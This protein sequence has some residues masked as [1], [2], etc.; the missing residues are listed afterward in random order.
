MSE[1][2]ERDARALWQAL[3]P[4]RGAAPPPGFRGRVMARVRAE[5]G[6]ITGQVPSLTVLRWA[7]GRTKAAAGFAAAAGLALGV[8]LAG[9][10]AP[11]ASLA[12]AGVEIETEIAATFGEGFG[13]AYWEALESED[14]SAWDLTR[15]SSELP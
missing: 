15:Q 11:A 6:V 3:D 13:G 7:P 14:P 4:A 5:A 1:R 12:E 2:G 9:W 8:G 10:L